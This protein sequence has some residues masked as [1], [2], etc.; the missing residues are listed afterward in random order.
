M[1]GDGAVATFDG[2]Q[3]AVLS[4]L[5]IRDELASIGISIRA[6]IH[7][8]EI[9]RRNGELGGLAVHIASRVMDVAETGGILV[10]GTVKDLVV[11]SPIGF[12]SCG[13]FDLKGVPGSWNLFEVQSN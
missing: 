11:G 5:A 8:G 13:A 7:T 10:S 3:R 6:G 2:P 12:E 4:A 9:E 1:T